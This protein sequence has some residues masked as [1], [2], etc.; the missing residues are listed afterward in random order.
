MMKVIILC[1]QIY[2]GIF[3]IF[4]FI[5]PSII[6]ILGAIYMREQVIFSS[7]EGMS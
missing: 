6:L 7:R 4:T 5:T 2:W 3:G 1:I